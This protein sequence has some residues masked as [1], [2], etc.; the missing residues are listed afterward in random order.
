M[1]EKNWRD[2]Y[3]DHVCKSALLGAISKDNAHAIAKTGLD[4][5]YET[6]DFFCTDGHVVKFKVRANLFAAFGGNL[7]CKKR[8]RT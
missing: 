1:N 4:E 5:M 8:A 3:T 7:G 2:K 6:F